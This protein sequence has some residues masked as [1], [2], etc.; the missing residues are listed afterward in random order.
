[1]EIKKN[2]SSWELLKAFR[3]KTRSGKP[4]IE[5]PILNDCD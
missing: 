2:A 3:L 1:M 4:S 5:F